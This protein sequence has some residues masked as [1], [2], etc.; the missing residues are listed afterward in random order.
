MEEKYE[1]FY[2]LIVTG[3]IKAYVKLYQRFPFLTEQFEDKIFRLIL[4]LT[5]RR[6]KPPLS[7]L[8]SLSV[9]TSGENNQM[10]LGLPLAT[11]KL[12][13]VFLDDHLFLQNGFGR[14]QIKSVFCYT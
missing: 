12:R 7:Q 14:F 11:T 3:N 10:S 13:R 5:L 4:H 9:F 8:E 1:L 2:N 6:I